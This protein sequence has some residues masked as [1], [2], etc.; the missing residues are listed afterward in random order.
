MTNH[1]DTL[2]NFNAWRRS[3]DDSIDQPDP[4]V[5]GEAIDH[6]LEAYPAVER[7]RDAWKEEAALRSKETAVWRH[8]AELLRAEL[9]KAD[10][11]LTANIDTFLALRSQLAEV[12]DEL[13]IAKRDLMS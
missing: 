12:L 10:E 11:A 6:L 4:K 5:I 8:E 3:D 9:T 1:L 2:R 13:A 7:E